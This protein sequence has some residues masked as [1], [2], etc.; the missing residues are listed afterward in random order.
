MALGTPTYGAVGGRGNNGTFTLNSAASGATTDVVLAVIA[1]KP[2]TANGGTITAPS[3]WTLIGSALAKGGYGTT[4][5]AGVG[6]VNTFIYRQ[7][8]PTTGGSNAIFTAGDNSAALGFQVRIPADGGTISLALTT[9]EDT[10]GDSTLVFAG[11]AD[12]GVKQG[13]LLLAGAALAASTVSGLLAQTFTQTGATFG[14]ATTGGGITGTGNQ[15]G[16]WGW[17]AVVTAGPGTAAPSAKA[18]A[19]G[20]TTNA[21]G[22]A[23]ILRIRETIAGAFNGTLGGVSA[24][25]AGAA[26]I[27]GTLGATLAPVSATSAAAVPALGESAI[28]L[29]GVFAAGEAQVLAAAAL[30]QT[31]GP[32]TAAGTGVSTIAGSGTGTVGPISLV[33]TATS[34]VR[35]PL[36]RRGVSIG[37]SRT[38]RA[39]DATRNAVATGG[40]R[41]AFGV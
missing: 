11:A 15:V 21:R 9:G 6:N 12:P 40:N 35:A 7:D 2:A 38:G 13:D 36:D 28:T 29:G 18:T 10:S 8:S 41:I 24:S 27:G 4:T 26:P 32:V 39:L 22:G 5:G 25:A 19:A 37:G 34:W 3:G 30:V 16:A 31:V 33:A 23:V 14:S 17:S 20:T 1:Q